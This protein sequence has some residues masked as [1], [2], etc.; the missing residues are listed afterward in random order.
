MNLQ[1]LA[2]RVEKAMGTTKERDL[3]PANVAVVLA[4]DGQQVTELDAQGDD[5][6]PEG[7]GGNR[8]T[9]VISSE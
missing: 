5:V 4:R 6:D 7:E 3:N 9:F 1:E 2:A 8:F